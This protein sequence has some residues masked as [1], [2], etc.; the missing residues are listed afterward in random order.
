MRVRCGVLPFLL[1]LVFC[2]SH[3]VFA[4]DDESTRYL[5]PLNR[6][7]R[8][9]RRNRQRRRSPIAPRSSPITLVVPTN[10][11]D[12][13]C[14]VASC[15][16]SVLDAM[17]CNDS[18]G[19]C[20]TCGSRISYLIDVLKYGATDAC[21]AVGVDQF[22][23]TCGGCRPDEQQLPSPVGSPP[24]PVV[25]PKADNV[26]QVA[27]CTRSVLDTLACSDSLAGCHTCE[28]RI[29]Y[30]IDVMKYGAIAACK[31]VGYDQF[32]GAC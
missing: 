16:Q 12:N 19:G 7:R 13:A 31:T 15:T 18:F 22:P 17:A 4:G 6:N 3:Q 24:S 21:K 5:R 26:C 32:I 30:L 8:R 14:K 20:H 25:E 10:P 27:T 23:L 28:S 9:R 1:L 11:D 2:L 29:N